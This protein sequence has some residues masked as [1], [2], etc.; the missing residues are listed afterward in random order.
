MERRIWGW[1]AIVILL[2]VNVLI[3]DAGEIEDVI[4][5]VVVQLVPEQDAEWRFT[6]EPA[7]ALWFWQFAEHHPFVT[8]DFGATVYL[9]IARGYGHRIWWGGSYRQAAG[10]DAGASITPFDPRHIDSAQLLAW[11][12]A[13]AKRRAIH[14]QIERWCY[15]E[16]D[17]HNRSAVF[18]TYTGAGVGTIAP[19]ESGEIPIRTRREQRLTFDF[20]AN[21]GPVING[22]LFDL[23]GD[24]MKRSGEGHAAFYLAHP[25][26]RNGVVEL[27]VTYD[28]LLLYERAIHRFRQR[29][30]VRLSIIS[31][32][33]H[34]GA[35]L[36]VGYHFK[37]DLIDRRAPENIY[38][39]TIFRF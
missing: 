1:M 26:G 17:I 9:E 8:W 2:L 24:D 37:D 34:G 31:Q 14:I 25:L 38:V 20:Y 28:A 23:F 22:G 10:Y 15:H 32:R 7:G 6:F 27:A 11:R 33:T 21:A 13:P 35:S 30:D 5:D 3:V 18:F 36:F 4:S 16:Q 29:G 19:P 39:G 12:W